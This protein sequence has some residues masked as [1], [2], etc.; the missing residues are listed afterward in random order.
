MYTDAETGFVYLRARY[1]DPATGQFLSRDPLVA[2][3]GSAYGYVDGNPLNFT[4]PLG[5]LTLKGF[6]KGAALGLGAA[7]LI[8]GTAGIATPG[9][10]VLGVSAATASTYLGVASTVA[11]V[12]VA[13]YDCRAKRDINCYGSIAEAVGG[14]VTTGFGALGTKLA[15]PALRVFANEAGFLF[16]AL[17]YGDF[18]NKPTILDRLRSGT[19]RGDRAVVGAYCPI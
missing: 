1:Y 7:A 15:S 3:T 9:L 6:L 16:D 14:G 18:S 17:A 13:Y 19:L 4:D 10:A 2:L 5:L 11:S 8:I 12:G